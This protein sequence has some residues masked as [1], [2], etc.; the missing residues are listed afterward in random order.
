MGDGQ[1]SAGVPVVKVPVFVTQ[2][3]IDTGV[4]FEPARCPI[5]LAV[6]RAVDPK[7]KVYARRIEWRGVGLGLCGAIMRDELEEWR[8]AFDH[9][10]KVK[11]IKF[12][13]EVPE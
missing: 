11:P 7:A 10:D 2:K 9:G 8:R 3:D 1:R 6:R 5:A 4:R 12:Y 13:L